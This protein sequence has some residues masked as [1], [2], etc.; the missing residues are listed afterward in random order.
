MFDTS[1]VHRSGDKTAASP[2]RFSSNT[3]RADK[4]LG[5]SMR[6]RR[7][8]GCSDS[9]KMS[10]ILTERQVDRSRHKGRQREILERVEPQIY[11]G[12]KCRGPR[13]SDHQQRPRRSPGR[14]VSAKTI[15]EMGRVTAR[16]Y[17]RRSFP[18]ESCQKET[19]M[20]VVRLARGVASRN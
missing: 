17:K 18:T 6:L 8:L 15:R 10:P 3:R 11:A 16:A 12:L 13:R 4:G 7:F 5:F 9:S 1:S 19:C 20:C 14:A 2:R